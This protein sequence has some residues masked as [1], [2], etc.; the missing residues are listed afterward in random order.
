MLAQ[1]LTYQINGRT[2]VV[3]AAVVLPPFVGVVWPVGSLIKFVYAAVS[4]ADLLFL[5]TAPNPITLKC[6]FSTGRFITISCSL[7]VTGP[8]VTYSKTLPSRV[9]GIGP[10]GEVVLAKNTFQGDTAQSQPIT[11]VSYSLP[12]GQ[13]I[14]LTCTTLQSVNVTTPA[15]PAQQY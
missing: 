3:P 5:L 4:N 14:V 2:L 12:A 9:L 10:L 8:T 13:V 11:T 1:D 7:S 15:F 6:I